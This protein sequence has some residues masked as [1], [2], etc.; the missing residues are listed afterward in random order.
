MERRSQSTFAT[1]RNDRVTFGVSASPF[2][3]NM[4]LKQN[5]LNLKQEY[6][7]TA[8]VDLDCFYLEIGLVG[9]H[10]IDDAICL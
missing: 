4:E 2:T 10:S 6:P 9:A 3:V 5:V 7:H 1:L 8:Q